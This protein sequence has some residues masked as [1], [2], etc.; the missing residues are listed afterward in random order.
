MRQDGVLAL[1]AVA[2]GNLCGCIPCEYCTRAGGTEEQDSALPI[3][4]PR[5]AVA[6]YGS[7]AAMDD[8]GGDAGSGRF[9]V[10]MKGALA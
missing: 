2:F 4:D 6:I 9:C 3:S 1:A 8:G 7:D 10:S 5:D